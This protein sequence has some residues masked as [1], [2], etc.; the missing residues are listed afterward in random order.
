MQV[1]LGLGWTQGIQEVT[2]KSDSRARTKI[3]T[4]VAWAA[5]KRKLGMVAE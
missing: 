3:A 4:G 2:R 1:I 5:K